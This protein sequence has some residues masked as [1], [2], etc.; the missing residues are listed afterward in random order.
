MNVNV[1]PIDRLDVI[2]VLVSPGRPARLR[3]LKRMS[4]VT[5]EVVPSG[6]DREVPQEVSS[7]QGT[8]VEMTVEDSDDDEEWVLDIRVFD[9]VESDDDSDSVFCWGTRIIRRPQ[10]VSGT[11]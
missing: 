9:P 10:T 1:A 7:R 4:Q 3:L 11:C 2:S 6:G 8:W 5:T